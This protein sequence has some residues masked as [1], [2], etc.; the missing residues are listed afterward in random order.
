[1]T[2]AVLQFWKVALWL[3]L[4]AFTCVASWAHAQQATDN[5]FTGKSWRIDNQGLGLSRRGFEAAARSDWHTHDGAQLIVAQEGGMRYQVQGQPMGTLSEHQSAYL[6]NGVAHWHGAPPNQQ[7]VQIS[8][9]FGSGIKWMEKVSE[10][11]YDG[12]A[13]R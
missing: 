6:P 3:G 11:Q 13:P 8:I 7:A 5:T 1:M 4:F 9:T 10:A 2:R 12:K